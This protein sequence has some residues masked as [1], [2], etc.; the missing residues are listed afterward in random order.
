[1]REF[2]DKLVLVVEDNVVNQQVALLELQYLGMRADA[3]GNGNEAIEAISNIKYDLVLMDCQMPEMD[4]FTA[5]KK[6]RELQSSVKSTPIIAMTAQAM[7]GD[8]E[9]CLEAG[10]NDYISKPIDRETLATVL[11]RWLTNPVDGPYV[12]DKPAGEKDLSSKES[13]NSESCR[14]KTVEPSETPRPYGAPEPAASR[15]AVEIKWPENSGQGAE[16]HPLQIL[17]PGYDNELFDHEFLRE[18]FG[19]RWVMLIHLFIESME[20]Q[21]NNLESS[22]SNSDKRKSL[23]DAHQLKSVAA[24]LRLGRLKTICATLEN[25]AR[26]ED[27]QASNDLFKSVKQLCARLAHDAKN[28]Q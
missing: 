21:L 6:I 16:V 27:W 3:V 10:M 22:I 20:K 18:K 1:M 4:G 25:A 12:Y 15:C 8:R 24:T 17:E 9:R 5:T 14:L 13:S 11:R 23:F 28:L 26:K 2:S 19:E 7:E